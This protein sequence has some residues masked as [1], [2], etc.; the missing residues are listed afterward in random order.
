M[1]HAEAHAQEDRSS[2]GANEDAFP[3]VGASESRDPLVNVSYRVGRPIRIGIT[4]DANA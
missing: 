2:T 1:C 3:D 4:N